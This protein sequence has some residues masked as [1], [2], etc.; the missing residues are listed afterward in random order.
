MTDRQLKRVPRFSYEA[1]SLTRAEDQ[2]SYKDLTLPLYDMQVL[3]PSKPNHVEVVQINRLVLV[4]G[5]VAPVR[6]ERSVQR[7]R[8]DGVDQIIV[9]CILE[10]ETDSAIE[11]VGRIVPARAVQFYDLSRAAWHEGRGAPS[12]NIVAPRDMFED[13]L[14]DL[15]PLHGLVLGPLNDLVVGHMEALARHGAALPACSASGVAKGTVELLCAAVSACT[16]AKAGVASPV[17]TIKAARALIASRLKDPD[18]TPDRLSHD[19]SVSRT[20]LYE[21]FAPYG[22]VSNYI[23]DARLRAVRRALL[24]PGERRKVS[25]LAYSHGFKSESHF[26][27]AFK[28][29]FGET[30][31]VL[32]RQLHEDAPE[33]VAQASGATVKTWLET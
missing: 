15:S 13:L 23:R 18:L 21:A 17:Q 31:Q 8:S 32:R 5:V 3:D 7:I 26:S 12:I 25:D 2:A 33:P 9:T 14:P 4:H 6:N 27:R 16:G 11:G 19:L 30:P 24:D 10:G 28:D 29:L 1:P 20:R 22:G